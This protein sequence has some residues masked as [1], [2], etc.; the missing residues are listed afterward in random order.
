MGFPSNHAQTGAVAVWGY[1]AA[2]V[3]RRWFLAVAALLAV[4][5]GM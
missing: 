3:R 1:L 5:I 2:F 4:F